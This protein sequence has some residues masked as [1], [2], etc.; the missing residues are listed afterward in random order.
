MNVIHL[1][2]NKSLAVEMTR[3][4]ERTEAKNEKII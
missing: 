4:Y 1:I 2:I 3:R